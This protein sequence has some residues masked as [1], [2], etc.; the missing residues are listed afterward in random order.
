MGK[1]ERFDNSFFLANFHLKLFFSSLRA[2]CL[3]PRFKV[4]NISQVI[5]GNPR[6]SFLKENVGV[7]ASWQCE[8]LLRIHKFNLKIGWR[9]PGEWGRNNFKIWICFLNS[10]IVY[11]APPDCHLIWVVFYQWALS[12]F[13][14]IALDYFLRIV[15]PFDNLLIQMPDD[16]VLLCFC[17]CFCF[18]QAGLHSLFHP[19]IQDGSTWSKFWAFFLQTLLFTVFLVT[20]EKI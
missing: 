4:T 11:L 7:D 1:E 15:E 14:L 10:L 19:T 18:L 17:L 5:Y 9:G 8:A 2:L 3:I 16:Q 6:I 12:S 20:I 13:L